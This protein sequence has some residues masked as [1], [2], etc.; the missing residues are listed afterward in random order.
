M[1]P[2]EPH[3]LLR[4]SGLGEALARLDTLDSERGAQAEEG[5]EAPARLRDFKRAAPG[6]KGDSE[7]VRGRDLLRGGVLGGEQPGGHRQFQPAQQSARSV[8]GAR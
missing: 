7:P 6:N 3:D 8:R 5:I 4:H 2:G 1:V